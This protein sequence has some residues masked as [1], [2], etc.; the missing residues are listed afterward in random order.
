MHCDFV[1]GSNESID[2]VFFGQG[3][4]VAVEADGLV[5]VGDVVEEG[6]RRK[7]AAGI[8]SFA[9]CSRAFPRL[10]SWRIIC[11]LLWRKR[12]CPNERSREIGIGTIIE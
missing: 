9:L 11:D 4:A 3:A 8:S 5:R 1:H 7:A 6:I 10:L 2:Y 12:L